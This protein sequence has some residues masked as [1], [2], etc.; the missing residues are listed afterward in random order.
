MKKIARKMTLNRET[1]RHLSAENLVDAVGGTSPDP[2]SR[3]S[4]VRTICPVQ[5]DTAASSCCA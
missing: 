3:V 2:P 1:L 5:N 4:C